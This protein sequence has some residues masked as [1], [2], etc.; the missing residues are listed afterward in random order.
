VGRKVGTCDVSTGIGCKVNWLSQG[1]FTAMTLRVR[2]VF[3]AP[4][5]KRTASSPGM[6]QD[7]NAKQT[8][9]VA[10]LATKV[11]L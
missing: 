4:A 8:F 3:T 5:L 2:K 9:K 6:I 11:L 10:L 1:V 7:L